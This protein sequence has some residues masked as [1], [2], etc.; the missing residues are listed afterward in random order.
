L[1]FSFAGVRVYG[2]AAPTVLRARL[3]R[4]GDTV[5]IALADDAG[6]PVATIDALAL[7][8]VRDS[9]AADSRFRVAWRP[10]AAPVR[11]D[12]AAVHIVAPDAHGEREPI[13][14]TRDA[15]AGVLAALHRH[16]VGGDGRLVVVTRGGVAV[17]ADDAAPDPVAAA[18]WGFVRSA[19]AEYPDRIAIVDLAPGAEVAAWCVADEPQLAVR[20]EH[21]YAP[22]LVAA[23]EPALAV[24]A[25]AWQLVSTTPGTLD[26]LVVRA[27]AADAL[28]PGPGQVALAVRAAGVNFRDVLITLGMYPGAGEAPSG[29]EGAG[30]VTA[31]GDGVDDLR[32]GDR[33][34]GMF[35]AAMAS[36]VVA[37]R[38]LVAPLPAGWSFADGAA[39]PIVYLTAWHGLI[40]LA[41][42]AAGQR[43]LIHAATGGV[44]EAAIAIARHVGAEVFATASPGKWPVLRAAG[45]DDDHIASSRDLGFAERWAGAEIDVVLNALAGPFVDASLG[46]MRR[47]GAFIELGK[48]DLRDAAAITAAH[49]VRYLAFDLAALAPDH[50]ARMLRD[51]LAGFAAGAL[52]RPRPVVRDVRD[53]R[54]VFRALGQGHTIGKRVLAI[55]RRLDPDGAVL[56]TGGTGGLGALVA[57]HLITRH[58]VRH[59]VLASRRADAA[60]ALADELRG[61]GA[62]TVELAACD[63]GDRDALAR[64]FTRRFTGIVHAAGITDD[65][66]LATMTPDRV[67]RVLRSKADAA[68]HLHALAGDE[69]AMFVMFSS[70]AGTLGNAGQVSY[71]AANAFLDG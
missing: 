48:T 16:V 30:V 57:R 33:V 67:D 66:A 51:V 58:G 12:D 21:A 63:V 49:G 13:A 5:A 23:G 4:R 19:Q 11:A 7:R 39:M 29:G 42:L 43:V 3:A 56:I 27:L 32:V 68:W 60:T 52:A 61:L 70:V 41:G 59:L 44:G 62:E 36:D 8:A 22:R 45:L 25:A 38:R 71:A 50:V 6:A 28:R 15:L 53:A 37:D 14:A 69:P 35:P 65:G 46:V 31:L 55:P 26:G 40:E 54:E 2:A 34:L 18:V 17:S 20:G 9:A 1:P 64:L 10:V 47:G 24:P